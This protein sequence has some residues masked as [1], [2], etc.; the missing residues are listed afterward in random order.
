VYS[1]SG[2]GNE[3]NTKTSLDKAANTRGT[4]IEGKAGKEESGKPACAKLIG[5]GA[6]EA[7]DLFEAED[8]MVLIGEVAVILL[9]LLVSCD[10]RCQ[11]GARRRKRL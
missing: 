9:V 4:D 8:N 3:T 11:Q 10:G 1:A 2:A 5:D 7:V 6:D